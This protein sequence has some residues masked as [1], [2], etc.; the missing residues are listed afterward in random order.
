MRAVVQRVRRAE[1]SVAGETIARIEH[2]LLVLLGVHKE[3]DEVCSGRLSRKIANLRIFE[4]SQMGKM[5][6]SVKEV[7]GAVLVVSQFTLYGQIERGNRPDFSAAAPYA[8]AEALYRDFCHRLEQ[9]GVPVATGRF[10]ARMEI[11]LLNDGPV[12]LIVEG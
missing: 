2:G 1:V 7:K 10:G 12:T 8:R 3:D 11:T 9:E 4:D 5:T 6:L